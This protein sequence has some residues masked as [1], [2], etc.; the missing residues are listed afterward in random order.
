[1]SPLSFLVHVIRLSWPCY[2]LLLAIM[3]PWDLLWRGMGWQT[4]TTRNRMMYCIIRGVVFSGAA[5][6]L[7]RVPGHEGLMW[8]E[9]TVHYWLRW[10]L[11]PYVFIPVLASLSAAAINRTILTVCETTPAT[12][13]A[14]SL[15]LACIGY[16][17]FSYNFFAATELH[18]GLP[19]LCAAHQGVSWLPY[20]VFRTTVSIYEAVFISS[21][22]CFLPLSIFQTWLSRSSNPSYAPLAERLFFLEKQSLWLLGWL[23]LV[24]VIFWTGNI[25]CGGPISYGIFLWGLTIIT[26]ATFLLFLWKWHLKI[27]VLRQHS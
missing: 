20:Y 3:L 14:W 13:P 16:E 23:L 1:M 10:N 5:F 27:A 4:W 2:V 24:G 8:G 19:C 11:L 25:L 21:I 9:D 17:T 26:P 15:I 18:Q 12:W 7:L 22:I 6:A